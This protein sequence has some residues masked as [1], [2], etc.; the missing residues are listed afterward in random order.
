MAACAANCRACRGEQ[1]WH[2]LDDSP[3]ALFAAA[4]GQ[5]LG[6]NVT[7]SSSQSLG[8]VT[9]PGACARHAT[10]VLTRLNGAVAPCNPA[11]SKST[12]Q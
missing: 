3:A 4:Q 12:E 5:S 10:P 1:C 7:P 11:V 2:H 6:P 9:G 8:P